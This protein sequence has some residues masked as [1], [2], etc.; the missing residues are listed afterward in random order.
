M[1]GFLFTVRSISEFI[2][3]IEASKSTKSVLILIFAFLSCLPSQ[4]VHM[5]NIFSALLNL[6]VDVGSNEK[7]F[8]EKN[9]T[10]KSSESWTRLLGKAKLVQPIFVTN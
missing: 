8:S 10:K 6:V 4:V 5:I 7:F 2:K 1:L 9:K 3:H